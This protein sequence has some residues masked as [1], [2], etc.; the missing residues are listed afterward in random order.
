[1]AEEHAVFLSAYAELMMQEIDICGSSPLGGGG[2]LLAYLVHASGKGG[3]PSSPR[4]FAVSRPMSRG[5]V[6]TIDRIDGCRF[7]MWTSL[8]IPIVPRGADGEV[9]PR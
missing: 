9:T 4:A 5:M 6:I 3:G 7:F 1:M 8:L 2:H